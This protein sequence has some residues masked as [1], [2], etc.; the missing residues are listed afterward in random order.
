MNIVVLS[1]T[2]LT[3]VTQE[4]QAVCAHYCDAADLVVHLGDWTAGCVLDY[5]EQYRL[6]AVCGNMDEASVR[7]RLPTKKTFRVG[8][9]TIG[10]THGWG[11]GG[12][13]TAQLLEKFDGVDVILF[14]HTHRPLVEKVD[15]RLLINPGSVFSGRGPQGRTLAVLKIGPSL[16]ANIIEL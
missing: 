7:L 12:D 10:L 1:D 14:G 8:S 9:I 3:R 11:Y 5:F 15:G 13:V 16:H 6:E 4:L 2:H